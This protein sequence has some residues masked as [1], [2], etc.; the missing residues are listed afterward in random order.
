[1]STEEAIKNLEG[2]VRY[3]NSRIEYEKD[4]AFD[5]E[6]AKKDVE[7]FTMAI[8]ALKDKLKQEKKNEN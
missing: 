2:F 1:M 7:S 8:E 4:P 6:Q 3:F 5:R